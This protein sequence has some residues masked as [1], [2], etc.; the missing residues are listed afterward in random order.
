MAYDHIPQSLRDT[1][2][3]CCW[4]YEQR[5]GKETKIPYNPRTGAKARPKCRHTEGDKQ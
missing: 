3:W 5:D 1:G 4:R 2:R